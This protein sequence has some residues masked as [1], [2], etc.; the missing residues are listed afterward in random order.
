VLA[1]SGAS[2]G[3]GGLSTVR[4]AY[5]RLPNRCRFTGVAHTG[6]EASSEMQP[7][8]PGSVR[9]RTEKHWGTFSGRS[10]KYAPARSP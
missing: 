2:Q 10:L 7:S 3:P 9:V 4:R 6:A 8:V 1:M 5:R